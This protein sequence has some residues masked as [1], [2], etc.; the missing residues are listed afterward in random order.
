M[1]FSAKGIEEAIKEVAYP[2]DKVTV[3]EMRTQYLVAELLLE[4]D[5]LRHGK[6]LCNL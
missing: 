3:K 4:M 6:I 2:N 1:G 5:K